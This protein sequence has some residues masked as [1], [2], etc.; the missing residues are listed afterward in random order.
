[1][2][3]QVIN[4]KATIEVVFNDYAQYFSISKLSIDKGAGN[5]L[6]LG[7]DKDYMHI[8]YA[9]GSSIVEILEYN[10][11]DSGAG[12]PFASMEALYDRLVEYMEDRTGTI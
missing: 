3:I 1:M 2:L 10:A 6:L 7:P 8:I 5:R 9:A 12:I 4:K 11:F